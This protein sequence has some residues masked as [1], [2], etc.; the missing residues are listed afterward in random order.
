MAFEG[1]TPGG[2]SYRNC[3]P[4][5]LRRSAIQTG[6]EGGYAVFDRFASGWAA[7]LADVRAK[8]TGHTVTGLGPTST[9]REFF[10]VYAPA[11]DSNHPEKYAQFVAARAGL[12]VGDTLGSLLED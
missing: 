5:N 12:S 10:L 1:W 9:V 2:R 7:L 6:S 11:G 4:G 8:C 3:N